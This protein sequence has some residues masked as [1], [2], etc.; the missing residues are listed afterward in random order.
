MQANGWLVGCLLFGLGCRV[1]IETAPVDDERGGAAANEGGGGSNVES[2]GGGGHSELPDRCPLGTTVDTAG[3]CARWDGPHPDWPTFG[4]HTATRLLDGRVLVVGEVIVRCEEACEAAGAALFDPAQA[5]WSI[6][7]AG[8]QPLSGRTATRLSDGRVLV[9]GGEDLTAMVRAD[10]LLFDPATNEFEE[11]ADL[12]TARA[13]HAAT[14]LTDGRVLLT[15]GYD[16]MEFWEARTSSTVVFDPELETWMEAAPLPAVRA[17]H[18]ATSLNDKVVVVGGLVGEDGHLLDSTALYLAD[19]DEWL[20][21]PGMP[22]GGGTVN[23][24][25]TA[26]SDGSLLVVGQSGAFRLD[27]RGDAFSLA[28]TMLAPRVNHVA[29]QLSDGRV[30]VTGGTPYQELHTPELYDPTLG[31]WSATAPNEP[32]IWSGSATALD[33]SR[34]LVVSGQALIFQSTR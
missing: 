10:A 29:A 16:E 4:E 30:L 9:S 20:E 24:T 12:P 17:R 25:A 26:L 27:S 19:Q 6:L 3:A 13:F 8:P 23:H 14:L 2:D 5:T 33:A 28:G 31:V 1:Q 11:V 7:E 15:G 21:G 32:A 18:T 22:V 34:V